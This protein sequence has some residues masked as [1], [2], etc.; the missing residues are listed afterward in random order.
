M[1]SKPNLTPDDLRQLIAYDPEVGAFTW[2]DR[3]ERYMPL[4]C[5]RNAWNTKHAGKPALIHSD[6]KRAYLS[7]HVL[8]TKIY[9]HRAAW[10][11]YHGEYP[12]EWI[13]HINGDPTDNRIANLRSCAQWQ[14]A[15]NRG[16]SKTSKPSSTSSMYCGVRQRTPGKWVAMIWAYNV[17]SKKSVPHWVGSYDTE[18]AAAK[19]Y[20]EAAL[21]LHGDFAKLNFSH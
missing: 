8:G 3:T 14:N 17:K 13:D 6:A 9:A 20:D 19:A 7:G 11:L 15:Q 1:A 4:A 18:V 16:A 21:R 12:K 5:V 2:L 10:V